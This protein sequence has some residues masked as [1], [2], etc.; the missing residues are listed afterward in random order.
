MGAAL[1]MLAAGVQVA[2]AVN[3]PQEEANNKLVLT[4]YSALN[5]AVA[6]GDLPDPNGGPPRLLFIFNFFR[7][8]DG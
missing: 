3:T 4:F 1:V 6:A 5:R 7:V 8:Q 2:Q